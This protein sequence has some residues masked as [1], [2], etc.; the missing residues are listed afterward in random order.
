MRYIPPARYT[1]D[2]IVEQCRA[3]INRPVVD[4]QDSTDLY[5][6]VR[7]FYHYDDA[8]LIAQ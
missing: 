6:E 5:A 1:F 7:K 4:T 2:E 3:A 8:D